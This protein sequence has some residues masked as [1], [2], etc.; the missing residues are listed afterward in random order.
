VK[1]MFYD[2]LKLEPIM[3]TLTIKKSSP[4]GSNHKF[5][6]GLSKLE[7]AHCITA[8][9]SEI[10]LTV[11]LSATTTAVSPALAKRLTQPARLDRIIKE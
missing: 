7:T 5:M 1:E 2:R 9:D 8:T 11:V 3:S 4:A 10:T 6:L